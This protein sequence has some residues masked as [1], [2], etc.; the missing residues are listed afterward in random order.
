MASPVMQSVV[1][2]LAT[3]VLLALART[4]R[5]RILFG[6]ATLLLL[7]L[8]GGAR[9]GPTG[10]PPPALAA[11][12]HRQPAL[13]RRMPA[14]GPRLAFCGQVAEALPY[15]GERTRADCRD[16]LDGGSSPAPVEP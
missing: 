5:T 8:A 9:V 2:M 10:G 6:V 15:L 1:W 11:A 12:R 3:M 7:A 4:D 16:E 14:G 13:P